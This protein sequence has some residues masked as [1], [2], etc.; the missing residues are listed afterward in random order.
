MYQ[1]SKLF[2]DSLSWPSELN[3]TGYTWTSG[4]SVSYSASF[5]LVFCFNCVS[6]FLWP[7]SC[8]GIWTGRAEK[9]SVWKSSTWMHKLSESSGK[10]APWHSCCGGIHSLMV[11]VK[12]VSAVGHAEPPCLHAVVF[13]IVSDI[14][15]PLEH[16]LGVQPENGHLWR[17]KI[18][19]TMLEKNKK[20]MWNSSWKVSR[21]YSWYSGYNFK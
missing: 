20:M 3:T 5:K 1:F 16:E 18:R 17:L 4:N 21:Y 7:I 6:F 9:H 2:L 12:K 19:A 8:G 11:P 13:L 15:R 10:T 14:H